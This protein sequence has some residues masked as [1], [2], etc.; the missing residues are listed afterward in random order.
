MIN[1]GDADW[2]SLVQFSL[3]DSPTLADELAELVL[4]GRKR[5]DVRGRER[6]FQ[7]RS[8]QATGDA[9][10]DP[11]AHEPLSKRSS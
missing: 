5:T 1:V 4:A 11:A 3:G 8:R 7:D 10:M 9:R 2:R 6:G